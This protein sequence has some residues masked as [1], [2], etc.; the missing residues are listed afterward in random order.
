M[1]TPDD[2]RREIRRLLLSGDNILKNR[3]G[4]TSVRKARERYERAADL[5]HVEG[6]QELIA[7][8]T[9]RLDAVPPPDAEAL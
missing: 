5:A 4:A 7:I 2:P 3:D 9:A 1:S 8:I 6:D